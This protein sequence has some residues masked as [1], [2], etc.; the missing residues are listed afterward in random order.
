MSGQ[1]NWTERLRDVIKKTYGKAGI[2][3][4]NFPKTKTVA[5][6]TKT[7]MLRLKIIS[8]KN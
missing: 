5:V 3:K 6:L 2:F 7:C 1:D 8:N 4:I